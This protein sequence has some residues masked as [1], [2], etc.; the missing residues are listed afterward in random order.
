M[1]FMTLGAHFIFA[2]LQAQRMFKVKFVKS[3]KNKYLTNAQKYKIMSV[4][5]GKP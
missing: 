2:C 4:R 3:N 1:R 5:G